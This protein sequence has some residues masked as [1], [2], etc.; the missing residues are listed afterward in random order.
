MRLAVVGMIIIKFF[1]MSANLKRFLIHCDTHWC[2]TDNTFRVLAKSEMDIEDLACDLAFD[3]FMSYAD[4]DD[5]L[6][7]LGYDPEEMS[8]EFRDEVLSEIDEGEY[9]H[10]SIEECTDDEEWNSYTDEI[11]EIKYPENE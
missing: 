4:Y 2:G 3:N 6:E 1:V 11:E 5:I 8:E 10:Y 9:W 7:E